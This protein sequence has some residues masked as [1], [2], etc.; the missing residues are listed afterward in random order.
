MEWRVSDT[1]IPLSPFYGKSIFPYFTC[2]S[3]HSDLIFGNL[4]SDFRFTEI[5]SVLYLTCVSLNGFGFI[6]G[7]Y[8]FFSRYLRV[9][10]ALS[11]LISRILRVTKFQKYIF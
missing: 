9:P 3:R 1:C 6:F 8:E 4:F 11:V 10:Y 5:N 7:N 2:I